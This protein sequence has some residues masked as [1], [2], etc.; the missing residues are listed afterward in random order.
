MIHRCKTLPEK[1]KMN[2]QYDRYI[3]IIPFIMNSN[4]IIYYHY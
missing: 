3:T 2:E 4:E 1:D